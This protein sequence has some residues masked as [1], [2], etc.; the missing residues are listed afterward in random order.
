M[1]K[2]KFGYGFA[3]FGLKL[4]FAKLGVV[5]VKWNHRLNSRMIDAAKGSDSE[6]KGGA[7][8]KVKIKI[9]SIKKYFYKVLYTGLKCSVTEFS[10]ETG[11]ITCCHIFVSLKILTV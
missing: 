11:K 9:V 3:M 4:I 2:R 5:G 8:K 6:G 1:C 7:F 10:C